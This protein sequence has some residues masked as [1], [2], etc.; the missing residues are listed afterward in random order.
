MLVVTLSWLPFN[1]QIHF[2]VTLATVKLVGVRDVN[3][4]DTF[5]PQ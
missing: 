4:F 1:V 2:V 5:K 3:A